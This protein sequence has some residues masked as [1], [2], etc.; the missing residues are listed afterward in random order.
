MTRK[1]K[2]IER[3]SVEHQIIGYGYTWWQGDPVPALPPL[4]GWRAV[5]T[6]DVTLL[7]RLHGRD[8]VEMRERIAAGNQPYVAFLGDA[9]VAYGWSASKTCGIGDAGLS[10]TLGP[11]DRFLWDF[12]TLNQ[13]RGHG[14]YPRLL[15]AMLANELGTAQRFWIG[16]DADN[17]ASR[18]GITKAGFTLV[19]T[20]VRSAHGQMLL[21]A[22]GDSGRGRADPMGRGL[23]FI[24][25]ASC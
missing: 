3:G 19:D 18:R 24:E 2:T 14:V 9:P 22:E 13:W 25:E 12:A 11:Q 5:P 21:R 15:Q 23:A 7:G 10:W 20:L 1:R 17:I 4:E 8:D 6:N 16:H